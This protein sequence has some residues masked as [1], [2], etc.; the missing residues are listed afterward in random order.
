MKTAW[1]QHRPLLLLLLVSITGCGQALGSKPKCEEQKIVEK[2]QEILDVIRAGSAHD[3]ARLAEAITA[4]QDVDRPILSRGGTL[5]F[6]A[7]SLGDIE[8]AKLLIDRGANVNFQD[9]D[10]MTPLFVATDNQHPEVATLLLKAGA[11]A[12]GK[13]CWGVS[14]LF[15]ASCNGNAEVAIAAIVAGADVNEKNKRGSTPIITALE[16]NHPEL[17]KIYAN[18]GASICTRDRNGTTVKDHIFPTKEKEEAYRVSVELWEAQQC[19]D[20]T[21]GGK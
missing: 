19:D 4:I 15:S 5:L 11:V 8:M 7:A 2:D 3:S 18:H 20:K 6:W 10:E 12:V 21:E 13:N 9:S 1:K 16:C 14:L 17:A